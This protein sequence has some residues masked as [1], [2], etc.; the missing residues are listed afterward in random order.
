VLLSSYNCW[1][2]K[3]IKPKVALTNSLS[4]CRL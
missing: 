3:N 1:S 2:H 4:N